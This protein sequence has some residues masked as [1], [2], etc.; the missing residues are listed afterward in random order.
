MISPNVPQTIPGDWF[1]IAKSVTYLGAERE[2]CLR[3]RMTIVLAS[4][5]LQKLRSWKEI[6]SLI[7]MIKYNMVQ[8]PRKH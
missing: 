2:E 8:F 6:E 1:L 5:K 4:F 3:K 7:Q